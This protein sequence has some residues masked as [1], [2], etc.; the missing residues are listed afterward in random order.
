MKRILAVVFLVLVTATFVGAEPERNPWANFK[1]GSWVKFRQTMK[2][3]M[4]GMK[5]EQVQETTT[6][7]VEVTESEIVLKI[8]SQITRKQNGQES[9]LPKSDNEVRYP[10][11]QEAPAVAKAGEKKAETGEEEL[12]IKDKK[13]KC[14]WSKFIQD[15]MGMVMEVKT[16]TSEEMPGNM[17]RAE[18]KADGQMK[19]TMLGEVLEFEVKE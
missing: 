16:W 7:L 6:T 19:G 10:I 14:K 1:P 12:T 17:V 3:D 13:V 9:K 5:M 18:G 15:Q 2:M 8:A 4:G 11:M